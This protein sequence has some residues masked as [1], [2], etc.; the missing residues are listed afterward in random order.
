MAGLALGMDPGL[1]YFA[2]FQPVAAVLAALPISIGGLGVREGTLA[3][4]F[5]TTRGRSP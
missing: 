4:L 2:C 5:S 3:R 1:V